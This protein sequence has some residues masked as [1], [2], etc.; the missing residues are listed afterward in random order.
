MA[1]RSE[2]Q[3]TIIAGELNAARE[4][5]D[6][7]YRAFITYLNAV[8]EIQREEDRSLQME[9]IGLSLVS[10][11]THEARQEAGIGF[12]LFQGGAVREEFCYE[13]VGHIVAF[14]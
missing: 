1:A 5:L 14:Q 4:A 6:A 8:Q 3:S 11:P 9:G 13:K 2:E 7:Q 10:L 12:L